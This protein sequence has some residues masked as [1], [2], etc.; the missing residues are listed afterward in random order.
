MEIIILTVTNNNGDEADITVWENKKAA[1]KS[2]CYGIAQIINSDW[3][4][5]NYDTLND[6]TKINEFVQDGDYIR[7]VNYYN[8]CDTVDSGYMYDYFW[9]ESRIIGKLIDSDIKINGIDEEDVD[10]DSCNAP[11]GQQLTFASGCGATCRR[12]NNPNEYA[13][14]DKQDGTY[15]CQ[16]CKM[17]SGVFGG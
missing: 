6:A 15:V 11:A 17:M 1:A 7:A 5:T 10:T 8:D 12:C 16:G 9:I 14:P 4:L 2:A 13:T 3:D